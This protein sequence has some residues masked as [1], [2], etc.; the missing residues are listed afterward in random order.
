FKAA[1]ESFEKA[2]LIDSK[3]A[4]LQFRWASSLLHLT[5]SDAREHFQHACDLSA[6]PFRADARINSTIR[7]VAR[8]LNNDGGMFCDAEMTLA[9]STPEQIAG[10]ESFF[11]HV[12]FNF[13]GNYRLGRLWAESVER[14]LPQ[15]ARA[16]AASSW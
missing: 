4:E 12:H 3:F 1:A 11:E 5:N 8:E 2:A 9:K 13:D 10:A 16:R 7:R 15:S 14:Y 6:L